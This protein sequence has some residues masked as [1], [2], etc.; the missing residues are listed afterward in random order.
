MGKCISTVSEVNIIPDV[1]DVPDDITIKQCK[2]F[3]V[4]IKSARVIK[5]Y[6]GDTFTVAAYL[7]T[8]GEDP[9]LYKFSCR[10]NGIDAPEINPKKN[11]PQFKNLSEKEIEVK[12]ANE[13]ELAEI[14]RDFLKDLILGE[15]VELSDHQKEKYGRILATVTL[16]DKNIGELM[17]KQRYAL[18][19]DGGTKQIPENWIIWHKTGEME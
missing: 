1:P 4:P 6:D 8:N 12:I 13:K 10:I 18:P 2:Q 9:V 15:I 3:L 19:Y 17:I 7:S 11:A 5:V 16:G 14:S